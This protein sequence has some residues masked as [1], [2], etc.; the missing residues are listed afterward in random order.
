MACRG[1][2]DSAPRCPGKFQKKG[3]GLA[4]SVSFPSGTR[5]LWVTAIP[6]GR[7]FVFLRTGMDKDSR[8]ALQVA[9]ELTAKFIEAR[10]VSPA[11]FAE[12][13]P[14]IFRVVHETIRK[15]SAS[16]EDKA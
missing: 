8:E 3:R 7:V 11:N 10:S 14:A 9:K 15:A 16:E 13:F 2:G 6:Q 1:A 12:F 5:L 4:V